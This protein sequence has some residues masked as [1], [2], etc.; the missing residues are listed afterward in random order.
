MMIKIDYTSEEYPNG[1]DNLGGVSLFGLFYNIHIDESPYYAGL[2]AKPSAKLPLRKIEF[3]KYPGSTE[4]EEAY[5]DEFK[6]VIGINGYPISLNS[7]H[8]FYW[9]VGL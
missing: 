3:Y 2:L 5:I 6:W 1:I 4:Y 7:N 9:L 8:I